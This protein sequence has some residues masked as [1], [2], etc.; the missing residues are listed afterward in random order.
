MS[1]TL[2]VTE[3]LACDYPSQPPSGDHGPAR[4]IAFSLGGARY[5]A[6]FCA[7]AELSIAVALDPFI[8]AARPAS[9]RE[10]K[11]P[12]RPAAHRRRTAGI[13]AWALENGLTDRERGRIPASVVA[14]YEAARGRQR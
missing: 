8:T 4:T 7:D 5:E 10:P 13:R 1:K 6:E 14:R 2:V 3:I 11:R 9:R 12:H